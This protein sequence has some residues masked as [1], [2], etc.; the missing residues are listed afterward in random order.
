MKI[1]IIKI[2][3]CSVKFCNN[4]VHIKG[5]FCKTC[6]NKIVS[7]SYDLYLCQICSDLIDIKRRKNPEHDINKRIKPVI[8]GDCSQF[9]DFEI[10]NDDDIC[11]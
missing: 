9:L 2:Y 6:L 5:V 1:K 4:P 3:K 8:C 11:E 10:G 7:Y